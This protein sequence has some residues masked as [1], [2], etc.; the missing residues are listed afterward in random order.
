MCDGA[1]GFARALRTVSELGVANRREK[2][3]TT[4]RRH[5][6]GSCVFAP[7]EHVTRWICPLSGTMRAF[8]FAGRHCFRQGF[9]K[10]ATTLNRVSSRPFA[11]ITFRQRLGTPRFRGKTILWSGAPSCRSIGSA[12][13]IVS[14]CSA[15]IPISTHPAN[16]SRLGS[17]ALPMPSKSRMLSTTLTKSPSKRT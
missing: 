3:A 10:S 15:A 12:L 1:C 6:R 17:S 13:L 9:Q 11:S 8:L 4:E 16:R 7:H 2:R 14:V 5:D